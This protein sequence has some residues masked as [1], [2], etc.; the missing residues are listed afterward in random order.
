MPRLNLVGEGLVSTCLLPTPQ[1][2]IIRHGVKKHNQ[3]IR[4]SQGTRAST[5]SRVTRGSRS[6]TGTK[7]G[8]ASRA[9]TA[10]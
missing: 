1:R 7:V 10:T 2:R 4:A 9:T 3:V 8:R 6:S 5:A